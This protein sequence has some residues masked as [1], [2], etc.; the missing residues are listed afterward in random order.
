MPY[1]IGIDVRKIQ[2]FGIGTYV[3]NLVRS[4]ARIDLENRYLLLC[5]PQDRDL[6]RDLP[7]N[8]QTV[9]E[10]APVYSARELLALSWRLYRSKLD[11]YHSTHYVLPAWVG[12]PVVVT[13]HDIIHLL[14][15]DFLP[16]RL[17][18][19]Y[20]QRMIRRSLHRGDRVIAVSQ[21]TKSDLMQYFDVDGGTIQVI[22]NGVEEAFRHRLP[23]EE[24][25]RWLRNLGIA[26]PYLLFVG[27]PKPHK[28]LDNVVKAYARARHL[29]VLDAPL[30]C[31][32]ARTGSEFKIRQR[33]EYL[34]IPDKVRI[35]GH[36]AQEALPAIYQGASLFLYPTLYEGF[37]LPVVEAMASGVPVI[38]SNTSALKEIAEG[39]AY[40]VDP[41]DIEGMAKAIASVMADPER[42]ARLA[43]RGARRAQDFDWDL[44]AR[45][46][47]DVYLAA[48]GG[49]D[50]DRTRTE[51]AV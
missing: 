27:N 12:S 20:A 6:L 25:Q 17:A 47:L 24:L 28:N 37:G 8:F 16:S 51:A 31:V 36:V 26:Q 49:R 30:I 46:T 13:I 45:K 19:L 1:T 48:I 41:L 34:G 44:T 43:E 3:R 5:R 4:L 23:D 21:S 15:P 33:A 11:L 2:D 7:V 9:P 39:Y 32:G 42:R 40:L 22:H 14:Y 29:A 35:L 50:L 18:F 10:S 38:T